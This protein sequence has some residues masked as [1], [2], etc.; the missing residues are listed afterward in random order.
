MNVLEEKIDAKCICQKA[1]IS[2]MKMSLSGKK[3]TFN[4]AR[5]KIRKYE[6][7]INR[8]GNTKSLPTDQSD[9]EQHI[10]LKI[11]C[12]ILATCWKNIFI[13]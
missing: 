3:T 5:S 9:Q 11:R 12:Y 4:N 1:D 6:Q 7:R 10:N 8:R 2:N 13:D